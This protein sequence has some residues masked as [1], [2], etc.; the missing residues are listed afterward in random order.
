[1]AP[2]APMSAE[3]QGKGGEEAGLMAKSPAEAA[4]SALTK[5]P[6]VDE[7]ENRFNLVWRLHVAAA[8]FMGIQAISYGVI[9]VDLQLVPTTGFPVYCNAEIAGNDCGGSWN[10]TPAVR[11][12]DSQN[13]IWLMSFFCA[14]ASADHIA[15][16]L[17][18]Y[19]YPDNAKWWLYKAQSNPF[20]MIEYS[21]SASA[22]VWAITQLCGIHDVHLIM[23]LCVGTCLGMLMGLVVE[24]LPR[25]DN[26][27][28]MIASSFIR[29]FIYTIACFSIFVPWLVIICYFF[30]GAAQSAPPDFVYAAF[31]GT[32][33]LFILFGI[34]S[35]L[36]RIAKRYDFETA[37][38]I[39]IVLSF[40]A[41]TFLAA[42]VFGGL[43]AA[44]DDD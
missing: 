42:D 29:N 22:M 14:L 18:A 19:Y 31:L 8:V 40:T 26:K 5:P 17:Y 7:P 16:S 21:I 27:D 44:A 36:N 23:M 12:L 1:M 6:A 13:P 37:E 38:I 25:E 11:R 4:D 24:F 39:Y 9:E 43:R 3:E 41:K 28:D 10:T 33:L 2:V 34:N 32:L 20:R 15:T 30:Q 35:Y